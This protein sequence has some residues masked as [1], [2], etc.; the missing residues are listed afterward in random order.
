MKLL[1]FELNGIRHIADERYPAI[2]WDYYV[3]V[4]KSGDNIYDVFGVF[5]QK[6]YIGEL[7]EGESEEIMREVR[8]IRALRI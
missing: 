2:G 5:M 1:V 6:D 7:S 8:A 4:I 3:R